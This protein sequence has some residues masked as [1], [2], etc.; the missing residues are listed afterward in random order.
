MKNIGL[1]YEFNQNLYLL[2]VPVLCACQ[3]ILG[4]ETQIRAGLEEMAPVALGRVLPTLPV[5]TKEA[6]Q[7]CWEQELH[8]CPSQTLGAGGA[9]LSLLCGFLDTALV[10]QVSLERH[11]SFHLFFLS[12][13]KL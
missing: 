12:M 3:K 4:M 6:E 2:F 5:T 9:T 13:E 1:I 10:S 7:E 8:K 11:G